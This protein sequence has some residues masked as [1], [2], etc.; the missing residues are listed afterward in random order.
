MVERV[1][2]AVSATITPSTDFGPVAAVTTI[3]STCCEPVDWAQAPVAPSRLPRMAV[4]ASHEAL[5]VVMEIPSNTR[6]IPQRVSA[7]PYRLS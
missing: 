1:F 4:V 3:S 2:G 7:S 6:A 5:L